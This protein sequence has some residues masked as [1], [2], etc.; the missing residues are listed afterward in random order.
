[1]SITLGTQGSYPG[2]L[3]A[4]VSGSTTTSGATLNQTWTTTVSSAWPGPFSLQ[5]GANFSDLSSY[6]L[7][8]NSAYPVAWIDAYRFALPWNADP[9][10]TRTGTMT[11]DLALNLAAVAPEL[12]FAASYQTAYGSSGSSG[13]TQTNQQLSTAS[14]TLSV[15]ITLVPAAGG[16]PQSGLLSGLTIT[17]SYQR[18]VKAAGIPVRSWLSVMGADA[19]TA[20]SVM[21]FRLYGND[22]AYYGGS[23][24]DQTYFFTAAPFYD[25]F[26]QPL[27]GTFASQ[28]SGYAYALYEPGTS[29]GISRSIGS[30]WADLIVPNRVQVSGEP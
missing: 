28:S 8:D 25:L 27:V 21:D 5:L 11:L 29:L 9:S 26:S 14:V 24:S 3:N 2:Q 7:T 13:V 18:V 20:A 16:S 23:I 22:I 15:P 4:N 1:M 30:N 19:S 17:P 12:S 6:D 10:A